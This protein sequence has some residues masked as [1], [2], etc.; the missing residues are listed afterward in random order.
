MQADVQQVVALPAIRACYVPCGGQ[1]AEV[2]H[3]GWVVVWPAFELGLYPFLVAKGD[4]ILLRAAVRDVQDDFVMTG[5]N[6]HAFPTKDI[7][8]E[9]QFY[10]CENFVAVPITRSGG[11][12]IVCEG[13]VLLV[14]GQSVVL[15][16]VNQHFLYPFLYGDTLAV[17]LCQCDDHVCL[18]DDIY[19]LT[20]CSVCLCPASLGA[21]PHLVT[22]SAVYALRFHHFVN[23][24]PG[25]E[26][27]AVPCAS[28]QKELSELC[29]SLRADVQAPASAG[30]ALRTFFPGSITNAKGQEQ[31]FLKQGHQGHVGRLLNNG[32]EEVGDD[33]VVCPSGAWQGGGFLVKVCFDP[34]GFVHSHLCVHGQTALHGEQVAHGD[35]KQGVGGILGQKE[36]EELADGVLQ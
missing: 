36:R 13:N 29:H 3:E 20:V 18:G 21:L 33:A 35:G 34:L 24:L 23:P 6:C 12:G 2:V 27:H 5:A 10:W 17:A 4:A 19:E 32:G 11:V 15:A 31:P 1:V 8:L 26:A 22:V 14:L 7:V 28:V 9:I 25:D 30:D 16:V